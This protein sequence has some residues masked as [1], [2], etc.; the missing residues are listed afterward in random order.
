[1]PV[2]KKKSS[3]VFTCSLTIVRHDLRW[4]VPNCDNTKHTPRQYISW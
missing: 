4:R 1:M 2:L 3:F